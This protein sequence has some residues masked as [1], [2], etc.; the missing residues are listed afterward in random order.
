MLKRPLTR[1]NR[2]LARVPR[3]AWFILLIV[4]L[5]SCTG[6][7]GL[8]ANIVIRMDAK[9][10]AFRSDGLPQNF[11]EVVAAIPQLESHTCG[12]LSLSAAYEAYG[13][14]S[15]E[16]NLRFRLGVDVNAVPLDST[17]T[18]TLHPDLLRV[19][20]QDRFAYRFVDPAAT[21]AQQQ[22]RDHLNA[23][24][25]ALVLIRRR[26]TG[27]LHWVVADHLADDQLRLHDSLESDAV[28]EPVEAF[29]DECVLSVILIEPA[30]LIT[31]KPDTGQAHRDGLRELV[32]VHD[33]LK[34]INEQAK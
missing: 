12:L 6:V 8:L 16:K 33:R 20:V 17:S 9:G 26:Q 25:L 2:R 32:R 22:I 4:I 7:V 29:L 5:I 21:D 34:V 30:D 28:H 18:G 11:A 27:G 23:S 24:H 10:N 3:L 1:L 15:D 13:I 19:L 31:T 14:A